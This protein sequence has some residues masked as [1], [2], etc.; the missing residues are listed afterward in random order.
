[1]KQNQKLREKVNNC[2]LCNTLRGN[3]PSMR[4]NFVSK[5]ETTISGNFF[6]IARPDKTCL[7][8]DDKHSHKYR[9]PSS[10]KLLAAKSNHISLLQKLK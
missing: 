2:S 8:S 5:N 9:N 7:I 4:T 10:P 1:M 3:V 6:S